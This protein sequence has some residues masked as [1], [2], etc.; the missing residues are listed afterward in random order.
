MHTHYIPPHPQQGTKYHRYVILVLPQ[1]SATE[2]I[3]IPAL[4]EADRLGFDFR[5]FAERYGFD[6]ATGGGAHMFREVWDPTV[7]HIYEHVLSK[8]AYGL[9]FFE[10]SSLVL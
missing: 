7:S 9:C 5:A 4:T 8:S 6:G 3:K 1:P 2:R 10:S